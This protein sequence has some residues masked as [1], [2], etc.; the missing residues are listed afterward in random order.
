MRKWIHLGVVEWAAEAAVMALEDEGIEWRSWT[1]ARI[2]GLVTSLFWK[3][4]SS[5]NFLYSLSFGRGDFSW[6]RKTQS[7][8][9]CIGR[10]EFCGLN[11]R[12]RSIRNTNAD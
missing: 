12:P 4:K 5:Y 2:S 10:S 9:K 7:L 11:I 3:K 1:L 8:S 6:I